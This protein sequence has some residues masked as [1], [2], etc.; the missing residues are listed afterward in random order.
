MKYFT[1]EA[2]SATAVDMKHFWPHITGDRAHMRPLAMEVIN[3]FDSIGGGRSESISKLADPDIKAKLG[4]IR[5]LEKGYEV[6]YQ[7]HKNSPT[8]H[9][10]INLKKA[11]R[12]LFKEGLINYRADKENNFLVQLQR[13]LKELQNPDKARK[14]RASNFFSPQT[15]GTKVYSPDFTNVLKKLMVKK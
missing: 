2:M 5:P 11:D 10:K 15:Y 8:K 9:T 4:K 14:V 13:P 7:E 3:D 6:A 12:A 1:K